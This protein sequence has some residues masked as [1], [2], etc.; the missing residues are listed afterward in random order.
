MLLAHS[1]AFLNTGTN[2][3]V[4]FICSPDFWPETHNI[5]PFSVWFT[6]QYHADISTH[7][8]QKRKQQEY[9]PPKVFMQF[10]SVSCNK[11]NHQPQLSPSESSLLLH[12]LTGQFGVVKPNP[13]SGTAGRQWSREREP[14]DPGSQYQCPQ[15]LGAGWPRT[16]SE[17]FAVSIFST[18]KLS[19]SHWLHRD[20]GTKIGTIYKAPDI[21][22]NHVICCIYII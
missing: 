9:F 10:S 20:V 17:V 2:L 18:G 12:F 14:S 5:L 21:Y 11:S 3:K 19:S 4:S 16:A 13:Q 8:K 22:D 15:H 7:Q 1:R 6:F